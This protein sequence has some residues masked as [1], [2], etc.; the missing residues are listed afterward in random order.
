MKITKE[1]EFTVKLGDQEFADLKELTR[2]VGHAKTPEDINPSI[3]SKLRIF[4]SEFSDKL[5]A[6]S[7]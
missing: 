3:W 7:I 6:I 5:H 1:T 4:A 2:M